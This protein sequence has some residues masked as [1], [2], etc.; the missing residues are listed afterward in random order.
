MIVK[1]YDYVRGNTAVTPQR[2]YDDIKKDKRYKNL[3]DEKKRKNKLIRQ[4]KIKKRNAAL[5]I[6]L[7]IFVL[8]VITVWRDT[9]VYN[10]QTQV[11]TIN[12]EIKTVNSNN[13]ALRVELLKHASLINIESN[14]KNKL[15]M[16][17]PVDAKKVD[18][19]LSKDYLSGIGNRNEDK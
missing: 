10:L 7:V 11:G 13:E 12:N 14:A 5:Q 19:D 17:S 2:K 4:E 16:I 6:A 1:E 3:E 8:G 18:I 15:K 9:K